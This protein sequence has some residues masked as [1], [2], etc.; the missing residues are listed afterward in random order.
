MLYSSREEV[1]EGND[2]I[3]YLATKE[4]LMKFAYVKDLYIVIEK[5]GDMSQKELA[6]VMD[7]TPPDKLN[8]LADAMRKKCDNEVS[9]GAWILAKPFKQDLW[10]QILDC[11]RHVALEC[12]SE[13][14]FI[15]TF[16][17]NTKELGVVV[18]PQELKISY[19]TYG[20]PESGIR[21][22]TLAIDYSNIPLD[23]HLVRCGSI[24]THA[25]SSAFHSGTDH[26]NEGENPGIH[27]VLG[28]LN[29]R[30]PD[31]DISIN[32]MSDKYTLRPQIL[33]PGWEDKPKGAP[34]KEWM[35]QI[36]FVENR[37][38]Q[39]KPAGSTAYKTAPASHVGASK[40]GYRG[41]LHG[42]WEWGHLPEE[43]LA[44]DEEYYD[45][46][47]RSVALDDE[48]DRRQEVP[49]GDANEEMSREILAKIFEDLISTANDFLVAM[50]TSEFKG[51]IKPEVLGDHGLVGE[52]IRSMS[53]DDFGDLV[54][55]FDDWEGSDNL[56]IDHI[57][58]E[59][60]EEEDLDTKELVVIDTDTGSQGAD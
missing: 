50:M 44:G 34:V 22:G 25:T 11:S 10:D 46:W 58:K 31:V 23:D 43:S 6:F 38:Y 27:M 39:G 8:L 24:H 59:F 15:M 45:Q 3:G 57:I 9:E 35:D 37:G 52:Y 49:D 33:I 55:A 21:S 60:A 13:F 4:G 30:T 41:P 56:V 19:N 17:L 36:T 16:D 26:T 18:P 54:N 2:G 47:S 1:M 40:G 20:K 14:M 48:R 32:I 42:N 5:C 7:L 12:K 28:K 53:D 29:E 51:H